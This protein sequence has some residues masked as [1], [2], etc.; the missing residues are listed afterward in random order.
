MKPVKYSR[1]TDECWRMVRALRHMPP[2]NAQRKER[3]RLFTG[4]MKQSEQFFRLSDH[5]GYESKPI[6][7]YYG[8]NQAARAIVAVGVQ[9]GEPW[10]LNGHGL[11]CP[12]LKNVKNLGDVIVEDEGKDKSFQK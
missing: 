11:T 6:L 2:G 10:E 3:R 4:S 5:A 7:L 8:L 12:A 9:Q 1:S